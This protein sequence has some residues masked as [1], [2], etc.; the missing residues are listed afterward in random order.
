MSLQPTPCLI[1]STR[2]APMPPSAKSAMP[3]AA[4]TGRIGSAG[5]PSPAIYSCSLL[6][7]VLLVVGLSG[8]HL[9]DCL[10][11]QL[12]GFFPMAAFIGSCFFQGGFGFLQV[13]ER[14]GHVRL[15]TRHLGVLRRIAQ[16]VDAESD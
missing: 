3:C 2:F 16:G 1:S 12:D 14:G 8:S 6:P 4:C 9:L 10:V 11:H 15:L 13:A 5:S 7:R